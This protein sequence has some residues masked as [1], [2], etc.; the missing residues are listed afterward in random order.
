MKSFVCFVVHDEREQY[1]MGHCQGLC[2]VEASIL[3]ASTYH[4]P[5][6]KICDFQHVCHL[7][8]YML[9]SEIPDLKIRF[10]I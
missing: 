10:A 2:P 6:D 9:H 5:Y 1:V 3:G 7:Q 8:Q 4:Y